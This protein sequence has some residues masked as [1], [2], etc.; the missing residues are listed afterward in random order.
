MTYEI[1]GRFVAL[2][3]FDF[4]PKSALKTPF[5]LKVSPKYFFTKNRP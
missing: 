2:S 4:D 1:F 3:I 5:E